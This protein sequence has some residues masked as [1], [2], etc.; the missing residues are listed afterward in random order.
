VDG[1]Y[2]FDP[3][4]ERIAEAP[5]KHFYAEGIVLDLS[6]LKPLKYDP[7]TR[8]VLETEWI[9]PQALEEACG[10]AG[11]TVRK[12]DVVLIRTGASRLWPRREYHFHFVPMRLEAVD[13]LIDRGVS[14]FGFD[15]ITLDIIP[16]YDLP[17]KHM[18]RRYSMHMENLTNLDRIPTPRFRFVAFPLKWEGAPC[19]PLRAFALLDQE[20]APP[21]RFLDLSH[22]IPAKPSWAAGAK[23]S[24]A[25]VTP[26]SNI[27]QTKLAATSL[28]A[29]NDHVS[30]HIDAPAHF[31][32]GGTSIDQ[33][34]P[35]LFLGAEAVWLDLSWKTPGD[36]ITP[37]DLERACRDAGE[38]PAPG[39]AVF[40][41][42]GI[43]RRW[44]EPGYHTII[45]P[46]SPGAI[47]WLLD[48]GIRLIGV[49]EDEFDADQIRWPAHFLL[50]ELEFYA[51]ENLALWPAVLEL[52]R[53]F[54]VV[55]A[56]LPIEG[57]TAAP[58][59]VVA[60]VG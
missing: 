3:L 49:D 51:I 58:C 1:T 54:R 52:P 14:L 56:P 17:H 55:A 53:R 6:H 28:L 41:Y 46:V 42:T 30:T 34:P 48:R 4:G 37:S 25:V 36:A 35:E 60:L 10:R 23:H 21:P 15:Q 31:R 2:H 32:P 26:W 59:R 44:G 22:P 33:M 27:F 43:S 20:P 7:F 45:V 8:Q 47:R 16:G 50:R 5:L 18:R 19:S 11:V 38:Q 29:F 24:R 9:T 12:G 13:W 40:L 39:N 57:A